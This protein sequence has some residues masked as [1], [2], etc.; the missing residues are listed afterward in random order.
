MKDEIRKVLGRRHV[1]SYFEIA[2]SILN[3]D[4]ISVSFF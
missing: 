2:G 3:E 1:Y 4:I